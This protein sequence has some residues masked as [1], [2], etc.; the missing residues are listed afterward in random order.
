AVG[1]GAV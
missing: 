1:I